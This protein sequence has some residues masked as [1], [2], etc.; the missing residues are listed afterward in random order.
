MLVQTVK[1]GYGNLPSAGLHS[2]NPA[3]PGSRVVDFACKIDSLQFLTTSG[4]QK[5]ENLFS[6]K[7][8]QPLFRHAERPL[9]YRERSIFYYPFYSIFAAALSSRKTTFG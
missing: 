8:P 7:W 3:L 4:R 1:K 2:C 9:C 6:K 5:L